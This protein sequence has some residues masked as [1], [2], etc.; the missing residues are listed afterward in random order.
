MV[1]HW[2][3]HIGQAAPGAVAD[4]KRLALDFAGAEITEDLREESARRIAAR[5]VSEEGREGIA[6][7]LNKGT[8]SW[9]V[10]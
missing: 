5:R 7:F 4:A 6:A 8:P 3:A 2:L 9:I 10:E 1:A